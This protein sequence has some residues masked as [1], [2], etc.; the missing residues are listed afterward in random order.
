MPDVQSCLMDFEVLDMAAHSVAEMAEV[1][2]L[3]WHD[4]HA[5]IVPA[6]LVKLRTRES[7]RSRSLEQYPKT[8]AAM[9]KGVLLGFVISRNDELYQMYV[10]EHAR[11]RGVASALIADA[12]QLILRDGYPKAWLDCAIGNVRAARFYEKSGWINVGSIVTELDTSDGPFPLKVWR[13]EKE[14]SS[15]G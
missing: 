14:L 11:G 6:G 3:G 15:S 5:E 12:E 4:A 8:R 13:F 10:A 1:W 9:A 7:F 2:H